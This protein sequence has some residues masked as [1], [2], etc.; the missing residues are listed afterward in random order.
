[1]MMAQRPALSTRLVDAAE[2]L[3]D[4]FHAR[5]ADGELCAND[6]AYLIPMIRFVTVQAQAVDLAQATAVA[7]MRGGAQSQR[8]SRLL[9]E[10]ETF[11]EQ[12]AA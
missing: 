1:M 11:N 5:Y 8:A 7:I 10:V 12:E 6:I 2:E 3:H 4:E 9:R